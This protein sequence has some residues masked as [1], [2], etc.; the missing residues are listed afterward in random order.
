MAWE[1]RHA[2]EGARC[3]VEALAAAVAVVEAPVDSVVAVAWVGVLVVVAAVVRAVAYQCYLILWHIKAVFRK[4][5][6]NLLITLI[7]KCFIGLRF[8]ICLHESPLFFQRN[9]KLFL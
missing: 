1:V 2:R 5:T 8:L 9:G 6:E 7:E 3:P 4:F